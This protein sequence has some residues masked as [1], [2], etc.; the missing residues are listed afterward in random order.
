MT[1]LSHTKPHFQILDGLRG[2]AALMVV[3]YHIFEGFAFAGGTAITTFNHGYLAVDFFFMLSGFVI[4]YAYD[5][6]WGKNSNGNTACRDRANNGKFTLW[7]F[8]K[9]RLI[10]LHP[11]VV[12]G[13]LIGSITFLL[14]GSLQWDGSHTPYGWIML[15]TVLGML[16]IPAWPGAGYDVRGN[17]E[18]YSLNGPSWSL[19]FEYLGNIAYALFIRKLSGR[20]LGLLTA[21]LGVLLG[22]LA[23]TDVSGYGMIGVGWT[24]DTI[25]F[26]GGF[27]RMMFPF[28]LG[29]LLWR[30]FRPVKIGCSIFWIASAVLF[31]IFS[32]PYIPACG[33]ICLNGV[34]EMACIGIV[35]PTIIWLGASEAMILCKCSTGEDKGSN[36]YSSNSFHRITQ[37]LC[38]FLGELSYPLYIVHYPVMYL[39]YAWLIKNEIYTLGECWQVVVGIMALCVVLAYTCLKLYDLPVRRWL[40]KR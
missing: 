11:M 37:N 25:N 23:I 21:T 10:R 14:G 13:A 9:R 12:M 7:S 1:T 22:W 17:G 15:A 16:L 28:S 24:L 3:W 38:N 20:G 19:F 29:M 35:F 4:S 32:V 18:M 30:N 2:A 8:F 6:R 31:A 5:S 33:E 36:A 27:I 39:F 26:F 34:Y 40:E